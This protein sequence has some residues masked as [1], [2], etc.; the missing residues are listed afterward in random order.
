[1]FTLGLWPTYFN[2]ARGACVWDLDG[3]EY[4]DMSIGGIGACVLGYADDG[5]I[6]NKILRKQ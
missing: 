6:I 4:L 5:A 2:R 1:M 3:R